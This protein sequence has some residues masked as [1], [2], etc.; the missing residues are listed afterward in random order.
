MSHFKSGIF[1]LAMGAGL[2]A[3]GAVAGWWWA[4][5]GDRMVMEAETQPSAPMVAEKKEKVLYWY[6]PMVP[7]QRF[8]KP[9]KSPFMDMELVPKYAAAES[10]MAGVK[11]DPVVTQNLGVRLANVAPIALATQ[12]EATGILGLN[13]REVALVQ[14]RAAG[15]VERVWPLAPGDVVKAGQPL[16]EL[17][18]PEWAA[19]Q[20]ELLAVAAA[21]DASL[22]AAA[23]ERLR[24]LGM[25][26]GL[27]REVEQNGRHQNYIVTAPIGGLVSVL[28]VRLGMTLT[29]G[30]S[31]VRI[32]GLS[33]VWLEVSV[34]EALA[35]AVQVGA[36][37]AVRF[38]AFPGQLMSGAVATIVPVLKGATRSLVLR[39]ELDNSDGRL[40]P[41]L[42]AQVTLKSNSAKTALAVPTEAILRTGKRALLM[43]VG[44][45][46][47]FVPTEVRLGPEI[48]DRTVIV[49]GVSAGQQV[50]AS[51]QFLLD[52]EASL[53]GI[54]P[55]ALDLN[56]GMQP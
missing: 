46:G 14:S 56:K 41:G 25:P 1:I 20:A 31:L 54:V 22:L 6:D 28:D 7:Q 30:Q 35:G 38:T 12:I 19:A 39:V 27:I 16:A 2:L 53:L 8:E 23:R 42:S 3:A 18:V 36:E 13:E 26:V 40:R 10:A 5:H 50:V 29:S 51:G 21:H 49:D 48:G 33:T 52:S 4:K 44:E 11:I 24:L 37:T 32:N 17:F 43:V 47:A 34:P 15:F 9:G 45:T 55:Q